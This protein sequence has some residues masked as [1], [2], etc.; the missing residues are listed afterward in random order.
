MT[1]YVV[2]FSLTQLAQWLERRIAHKRLGAAPVK[3]AEDGVPL[4]TPVV[5]QP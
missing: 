3:A 5:T 1:Y 4:P 2:C